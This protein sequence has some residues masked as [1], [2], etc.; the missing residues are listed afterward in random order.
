MSAGNGLAEN[1]TA[2]AIA[3]L[4]IVV[5]FAIGAAGLILP[6]IPGLLFLAIALMLVA[7]IFPAVGSRLRRNRTLRSYLDSAEGFGN[8]SWLG[9]LQYGALLTLRLFVDAIALGLYAGSRLLAFAVVK[10][11][12][13]R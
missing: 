13:Y 12:S 11:Q 3:V 10:Y 2:K 8:L 7:K 5:C 4:L 9:K 1:L 6:I